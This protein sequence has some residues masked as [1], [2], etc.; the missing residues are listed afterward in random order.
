MYEDARRV[1]AELSNILL[2][3]LKSRNLI[4]KTE[5]SAEALLLKLRKIKEAKWT[6]T[7]AYSYK[8]CALFTKLLTVKFGVGGTSSAKAAAVYPEKHRK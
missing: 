7:I 1:A 2:H 6:A 5:V 8:N 4:H 3:P